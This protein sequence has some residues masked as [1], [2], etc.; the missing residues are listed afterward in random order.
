MTYF[1]TA[2]QLQA[3][4]GKGN[5]MIQNRMPDPERKAVADAA[6]R[7]GVSAPELMRQCARAI[8]STEVGRRA[9]KSLLAHA[10][11]GARWQGNGCAIACVGGPLRI[12]PTAGAIDVLQAAIGP[13]PRIA[14]DG[15]FSE[16][17]G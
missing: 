7:L 17:R 4:A 14:G 10:D 15:G 8:S 2:P 9:L 5:S 1:R 3:Q 13:E 11:E 6:K 16:G 12:R